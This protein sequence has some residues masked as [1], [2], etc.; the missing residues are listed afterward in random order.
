M[1][2]IAGYLNFDGQPASPVIL[3]AMTDMLVHRGPDDEGHLVEN[4]LALG[5]RRL[6]IID[7][8]PSGH[9][10]MASRSGHLVIS[11]NGEIYNYRELRLELE[12]RG[13]AFHSESD[14]EVLLAALE[15]WDE[16][17]LQR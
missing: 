13:H 11:Y 16:G 2:G 5:H 3:K 6:S 15:E 12:A 4:G 17:C 1:C 10:P 8:T 7:L 9:Q 14:T